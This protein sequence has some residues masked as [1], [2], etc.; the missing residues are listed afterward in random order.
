MDAW[1]HEQMLA[2]GYPDTEL[3]LNEWCPYQEKTGTGLQGAE[4]A[5]IMVAMQKGHEDVLC[6]YDMRIKSPWYAPFFD[7]KTCRP[8]HGYYAAVAFNT[9]YKLGT[10][11][12]SDSDTEG[13][14]VLA[15]SNGTKN[16]MMVVNLTEKTQS[17][18]FEGV[19]LADARISVIDDLRLLSWAPHAKEIEKNTVYLIEW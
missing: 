19:D 14:Y 6:I 13:L 4:V 8:H 2:Y 10:E 18:A 12:A 9:L 5:G 1:V 15:A 11:V 7:C 3:H 17:L 16:A